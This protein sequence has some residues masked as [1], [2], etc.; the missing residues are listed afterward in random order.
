MNYI[1]NLN[2]NN[3]LTDSSYKR[4]FNFNSINEKLFKKES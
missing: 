3:K 1:F 4:N 2:F